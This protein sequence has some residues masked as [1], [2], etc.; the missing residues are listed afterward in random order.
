VIDLT[1]PASALRL[2]APLLFAALGGILS[3]RAGVINIA[4]EG[5]L[6]AGAFAAAVTTLA[7]GDPWAGAAAG[8][9]AGILVGL[10]HALFGVV[11]RGDQIVVGVALNLLVAGATMF[12]MNLLYGSSANTPPFGGLGDGG[13]CRRSCRWRCCSARRWTRCC[14][15]RGS[16][17]ASAPWA[18]TPRPRSRWGS[19]RRAC[20]WRRWRRPARWPGSAARTWRWTPRSS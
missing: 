9:A 10:L 7:T 16:G 18:S 4:L 12:L 8:A 1:L 6:L 14:A 20:A 3:E 5:K 13:G 2:A 19:A 17:S 15:S 11:L